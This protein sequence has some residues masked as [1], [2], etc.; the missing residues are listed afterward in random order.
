MLGLL[1]LCQLPGRSTSLRILWVAQIMSSFFPAEARIYNEHRQLLSGGVQDLAS[2][3]SPSTSCNDDARGGPGLLA[4][5]GARTPAYEG[6]PGSAA[7]ASWRGGQDDQIYRLR[8]AHSRS[9]APTFYSSFRLKHAEESAA[10][11][12]ALRI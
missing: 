5:F 10:P 3:E 4:N 6:G 7:H 8:R 2:S 12:S 11:L 1:V 9:G